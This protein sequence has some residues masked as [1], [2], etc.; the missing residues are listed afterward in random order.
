MK[1]CLALLA[2]VW[3]ALG[4][5][6][7]LAAQ[8][9][10]VVMHMREL[11]AAQ[12]VK[13][14]GMGWNL[15]NTM[16]GHSGFTP[17]ETTWQPTIT[18]Q[19]TIDAVHGA[20]FNTMRLPVT[21]GTM[22]DDGNGYQIDEAWLSRVQ[23]I[24]DYAVKQDMYVIIN[25]HHD[26]AEQTGWLRIA[27]EGEQLEQVK[28][29]FAAVWQQIALHFRDYD[30]HILFE[31]MNEVVGDDNTPEG[32]KHDY[33]T[34]MELNQLFVDTVRATGGN[35]ARRWL[36]CAPRYTNI[37]NTL[38]PDNGF[39][40]PKDTLPQARLM[41]SVH[42][43]DYS[44]GILDN[45]GATYW[46]EEKA[47]ALSKQFEKL[48][49]QFVDKG[50][51]VVLG[52]YGAANK[53]ND[54]NRAYYYEAMNRMCALSGVVPCAWD[55]GYYDR[56]RD[57]DY[58][59]ALFD[60]AT[61]E[62]LFPGVISAML[63]GYEHPIAGGMRTNMLM[64]VK[65]QDAAVAPETSPYTSIT[66]DKKQLFMTSGEE[67][68][69]AAA[70]QPTDSTDVLIFTSSNPEVVSVYRGL[71][72]AKAPG[73]AKITVASHA[74]DAYADVIV[75]VKPASIETPI[76]QI[77]AE[78]SITLTKGE[79]KQLGVSLSP[80]EHADS[81]YF[82]SGDPRIVSVN[83]LGK[84]IALAPG[85]T[86]VTIA[87]AS[88]LNKA[89]SVTVNDAAPEAE[90]G[91]SMAVGV[92]YTDSAHGYYANETG[93]TMLITGDGTYTL[94]FDIA[95]DLSEDAKAAG[96]DSLSGAGAIYLYDV[97]GRANVLS[98]CNIHYD[99]ILLD[100]APLTIKEHEPKSAIKTNG[101]LDTNDP[102]NAWDGSI[103][104]EATVVGDHEIAY[105]GNPAPKS[106]SITFSLSDWAYAK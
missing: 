13:E 5:T 100:G 33:K 18:T 34:I 96:V 77:T 90:A 24:A 22:I 19:K 15:G 4:A 75:V 64:L 56:S 62:E 39:T 106:I 41:L 102:I 38:N 52:E 30:E 42:D 88:G 9:S 76:T 95:K 20:G 86:R 10:G 87:T 43:Y 2:A 17:G 105:A 11:D 91:V 46:S 7:A 72:R 27:Y 89:V 53:N 61:G 35:N 59:M 47:L 28:K 74:G 50:V 60:R 1:K 98:S 84:L 82:I 51:P 36:I 25:I 45:M 97:S 104:D 101:K 26:G 93:E 92:Y 69:L 48:K 16:D 54:G 3:L 21:W 71:L 55:I 94:S 31:D 32:W 58:T 80:Q 73:S 29:K 67:L 70:A 14:M 78:E 99:E 23:D 6:P 57:P 65:P 44:F 49:A 83:P 68:T 37:I 81:V 63:R 66:L 40:M 8:D 103:T 85:Q 79:S 12:I